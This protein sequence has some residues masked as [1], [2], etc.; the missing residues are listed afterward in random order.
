MTEIREI[1]PADLGACA[2]LLIDAYNCEPWNNRWTAE[3]AKRYLSEFLGAERFKGFLLLSDGEASGAML[4]HSRT[5]WTGDEYYVDEFYV[6]TARQGKG[7]G[8]ALLRHAE[9]YVRSQGWEGVTLLT[10]RHFPARE[11]YLK[12]G[13]K[14]AEHVLF[15]YK[16]L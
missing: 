12:R 8:S 2:A 6:A 16:I 11:F 3:S 9:E 13:F 10:N 5:W 1:T 15:M 14:E 4:G 7:L